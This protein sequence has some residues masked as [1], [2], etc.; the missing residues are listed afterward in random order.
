MQQASNLYKNNQNVHPSGI[1]VWITEDTI[2]KWRNWLWENLEI[3][4]VR[5]NLEKLTGNEFKTAQTYF[6]HFKS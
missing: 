1:P 3:E 4:S 6:G 2:L 5:M